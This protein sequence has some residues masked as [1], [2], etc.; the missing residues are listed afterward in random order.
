MRN[1]EKTSETDRV[2]VTSST[3]KGFFPKTRWSVVAAA[4]T[5]RTA[6]QRALEQLCRDY[7]P[8]VYA[9]I[10]SRGRRVEDAKDLTQSFFVSLITR[11]DFGGLSPEL[12][13][14]RSFLLKSVQHFLANERR[15]D[16]ALKRGGGV[17]HV[18]IDTEQ[19]EAWFA[20]AGSCPTPETVFERQWAVRLLDRV[21]ERL[22]VVYRR[23]GKTEMFQRLRPLIAGGE[24]RGRYSELASSLRT[25]EAS[26]RMMV[27]R[28]RK[29]YR[30]LLNE[31][32][33]QTVAD[34]SEIDDEID[35]LFRVLQKR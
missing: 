18:S 12:G 20:Q 17:D 30:A 16:E 25:S 3:G 27:F 5:D 21:M 23:E 9:Y 26:L 6:R 13:R 11:C 19:G 22:A 14:F 29:R 7:W 24:D 28:M 1:E 35:E 31:E 34:P 8:P 10:R 2:G 33:A 15:R 4:G 32:I